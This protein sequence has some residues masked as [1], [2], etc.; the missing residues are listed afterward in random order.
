MPSQVNTTGDIEIRKAKHSDI[1]VIHKVLAEAFQ[2]YRHDYTEEAFNATV[3]P[4]DEIEKRLQEPRTVVLVVEYRHIIIGTATILMH[5]R[6]ELY[7]Q[8]MAVRPTTQKR[9]IGHRLLEEID[10]H[11]R[12]KKCT[13]VSLECYEPLTKAI[14][15][16]EKHGYKRTGKTRSYHGITIFEMKKEIKLNV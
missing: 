8:S 9:G 14:A 5:K 16:Y 6:G 13:T 1:Y 12:H 3:V 15:L 4:P 2:P 7:I 11:A 10:R